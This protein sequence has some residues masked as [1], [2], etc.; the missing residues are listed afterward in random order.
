MRRLPPAI[1]NIVIDELIQSVINS[2]LDSR[3]CDMVADTL[4]SISTI[5]TR[6]KVL[7]RL[8]TVCSLASFISLRLRLQTD[9]FTSLF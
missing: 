2:E 3:K 9:A 4:I 7:S 5:H 1:L 8:R 6:A